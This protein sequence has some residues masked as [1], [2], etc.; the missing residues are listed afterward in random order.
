M[1]HW[2][3]SPLKVLGLRGRLH[4]L[5]KVLFSA[6]KLSVLLRTGP[7]SELKTGPFQAHVNAP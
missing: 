3:T 7:K 5:E 6:P 2:I 4:E 1:P